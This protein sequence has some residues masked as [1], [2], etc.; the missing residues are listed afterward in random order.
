VTTGALFEMRTARSSITVDPA[1]GARLTSLI[2]DGAELL[3]ASTPPPGAPPAI[4]SGSFLMAPFVGRTDHGRFEFGG[5]SYQLPLNFG[6]NAMHGFVFDRPWRVTDD[7]VAIDLDERWPFGGS[8]TQRFE[9]GENS[10]RI[11]ATIS[12]EEREMPAILGFHPW[13]RDELEGGGLA[14]FDFEPGTRYICDDNGIPT[15][16]IAG[17][18]PRPWD[19]SFTDV[20]IPPS[21]WWADGP[22]LTIETDG[23]HWIVCETMPDAFCIEPLSGP[24]N[25]LAAGGYATVGP[26]HPLTLSMTLHWS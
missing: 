6:P 12:N 2:V 25:G 18:G 17:G 21:I 5:E 10:L 8:V 7:G 11:S 13:F 19:D 26:G 24:V 14:S 23:S 22:T 15:H 1:D 3:G 16:T 20:A 9:L 4:F